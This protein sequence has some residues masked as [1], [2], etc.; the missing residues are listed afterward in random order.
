MGCEQIREV[1]RLWGLGQSQSAI[2]ASAGVSRAAVQD[3]TR[4]ARAVGLGSAE[5]L[6]LTDEALFER[7]GK[8]GGGRVRVAVEFD[9]AWITNELRKKG[10]TRELLFRELIARGGMPVGYATFCRRIEEHE[11][12]TGVVLRQVYTPGEYWLVDYAGLTVPI[13]SACRTKI[14]FEAQVFVGTLGASGLI[15]CEATASQKIEHFLGS[16]VR[17]FEYYGGVPLIITPDNLKSGVKTV[18]WFEPDLTRAYRE[19]AEHYGLVILPTR[20][21]KPRDKGKVE[22]AVLDVERWVLAPLRHE[23]FTCVGDLNAAMRPLREELNRREMREY[24]A[25]RWELFE[26]IEKNALKPLPQCRFEVTTSKIARVNIDYHIEFE[27]HWYSVPYQLL[28]QEVWVKAGEFLVTIFLGSKCVAQHAR[29]RIPYRYTT[30]A[31]HMPPNHRAIRTRTTEGFVAWA[32]TVGTATTQLVEKILGSAQ[33]EQQAYRT[34]LGLQRLAKTYSP[35][36]LEAA[37]VEAHRIGTCSCKGLRTIIA[38]QYAEKVKQAPVQIIPHGNLR[39]PNVF[40]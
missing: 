22:R 20:V 9:Y 26:R 27:K 24:G 11:R 1:I 13:W 3:Y 6:G 32:G 5:V 38:R 30:V 33:H 28:R 2:A 25:S 31:E 35:L 29:N 12:K 34:V 37:A 21:R 8:R 18:D 14:I 16:H 36:A 7:L 23:K 40:H 15:F 39:D 19:L 17:G 4:R 10:V